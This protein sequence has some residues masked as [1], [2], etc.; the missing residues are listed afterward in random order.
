MHNI[1]TFCLDIIIRQIQ[2]EELIINRHE[3]VKVFTE[4]IR[5]NTVKIEDNIEYRYNAIFKILSY[6]N[7]SP[8]YK[9]YYHEIERYNEVF[10]I[11]KDIFSQ[12]NTQTMKDPFSYRTQII[13]LLATFKNM[14]INDGFKESNFERD[15]AIE[16]LFIEQE[17]ECL[18]PE[19]FN[20]EEDIY[21]IIMVAKT[22]NQASYYISKENIQTISNMKIFDF[23]NWY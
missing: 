15:I 13:W 2:D 8:N 5:D 23:I 16:Y 10:Q 9:K 6:I 7:L 1:E 12:L 20:F 22:D 21:G 17:L 19:V 11:A 18:V 4:T 3:E 14:L